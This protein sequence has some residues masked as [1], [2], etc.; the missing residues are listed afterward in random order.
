MA[1]FPFSRTATGLQSP[2]DRFG[3]LSLASAVL[4]LVIAGWLAI[5]W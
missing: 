5:L 1:K 4:F 3:I 2:F